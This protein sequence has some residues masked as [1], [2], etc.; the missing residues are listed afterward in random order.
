M[1]NLGKCFELIKHNQDPQ[2][3]L[4]HFKNNRLVKALEDL[5]PREKEELLRIVEQLDMHIPEPLQPRG[6]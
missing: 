6:R 2:S 1:N 5:S 3:D 4:L